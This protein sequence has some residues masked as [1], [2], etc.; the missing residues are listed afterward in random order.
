MS[1]LYTDPDTVL[2]KAK[3]EDVVIDFVGRVGARPYMKYTPYE[4]NRGT[5]V[6]MWSCISYTFKRMPHRTLLS[7]P[8]IVDPAECDDYN[9]RMFTDEWVWNQVRKSRGVELIPIEDSPFGSD[10]MEWYDD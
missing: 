9:V 4:N 8:T 7:H 10:F 6:N 2:E 3:T 5:K 1:D